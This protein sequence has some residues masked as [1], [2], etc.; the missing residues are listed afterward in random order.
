M[1][2]MASKLQLKK[3]YSSISGKTTQGTG[4]RNGF[5]LGPMRSS[6]GFRKMSPGQAEDTSLEDQKLHREG[7]PSPAI[8]NE[9]SC[10]ES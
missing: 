4:S 9:F 2:K 10:A 8:R 1:R 5:H 7:V 6:S 3:L